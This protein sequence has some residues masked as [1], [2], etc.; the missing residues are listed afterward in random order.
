VREV[1]CP[2]RTSFFLIARPHPASGS[3]GHKGKCQGVPRASATRGYHRRSAV[4]RE[5]LVSNMHLETVRF[6]CCHERKSGRTEMPLLHPVPCL[7]IDRVCLLDHMLASS[8]RAHSRCAN[9]I[10]LVST[11]SQ[12]LVRYTHDRHRR[13]SPTVSP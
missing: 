11:Q 12:L 7:H 13:E 2:Q 4:D 8:P 5:F 10:F 1:R 6:Q 9:R 3:Y